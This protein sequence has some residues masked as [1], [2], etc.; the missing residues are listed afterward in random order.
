ML[1][2]AEGFSRLSTLPGATEFLNDAQ[3][4]FF[5]LGEQL[6]GR[7]ST[8]TTNLSCAFFLPKVCNMPLGMVWP[9]TICFE[10]FYSS[11][12]VLKGGYSVFL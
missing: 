10:D 1:A 5:P 6:A 7:V 12:E 3:P 2:A 4:L 8:P 9:I 11:I